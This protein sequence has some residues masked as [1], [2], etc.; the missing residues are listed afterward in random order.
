M[1]L[2]NKPTSRN[3]YV[4]QCWKR[5]YS[6]SDLTPR[7]EAVRCSHDAHRQIQPDDDDA[8]R[9]QTNAFPPGEDPFPTPDHSNSICSVGL[10]EDEQRPGYR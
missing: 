8:I 2:A 3:L 1:I 5:I 9:L 4:K 6:L 10:G 7:L